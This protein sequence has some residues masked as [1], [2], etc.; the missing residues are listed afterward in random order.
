MTFSRSCF[1]V[2]QAPLFFELGFKID[3]QTSTFPGEFVW[4]ITLCPILTLVKTD[5]VYFACF[6]CLRVVGSS[7]VE[8]ASL[9]C[10]VDRL[11]PVAALR[12]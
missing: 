6:A 7:I 5:R 2:E 10:V 3:D 1:A 11:E 4:L 8:L 12:V 9:N